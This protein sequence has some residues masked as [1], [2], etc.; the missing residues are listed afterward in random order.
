MGVDFKKIINDDLINSFL[1]NDLNDDLF[2]E[3]I[4]TYLEIMSDI[5][6]EYKE[7]TKSLVIK[8]GNLNDNDVNP[9]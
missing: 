9:K 3:I 5:N 4:K 1:D 6:N 2:D 7:K 8:N